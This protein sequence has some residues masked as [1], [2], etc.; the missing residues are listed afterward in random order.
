MIK[1]PMKFEVQAAAR[2]GIQSTWS[3]NSGSLPPITMAIPLDFKGPGGGY[4][5]ED[6]FALAILNCLI[7]V[8]KVYCDKEKVTFDEIKTKAELTISKLSA[9]NMIAA[10]H[11][12]LYLDVTGASDGERA[13]KVMDNAVKDCIISNSV[14]LGKTFHITVQ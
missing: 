10:T 5:P 2:S 6:L 11:I 14:K 7:A 13:R 3:A 12:D 9:E 4:S 1:F 8:F